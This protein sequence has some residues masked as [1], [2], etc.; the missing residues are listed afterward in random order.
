[1]TAPIAS[2]S[3]I[4]SGIQWRDLVD[5]IMEVEATRRFNPLANRQAAL[6]NQADAWRQFQGVAGTFRDAARRL[7]QLST[8]NV[9]RTTVGR[10]ATGRDVAT[11]SAGERAQPGT[12]ALEVLSTARAEKLGGAVYASS[13]AA[14]GIA[15]S[16][17]V[18]G[19]SITLTADDT[20]TTLRDRINASASGA[21][22]AGVTA[23]L[24]SAGDGV[25]LVL[26]AVSTGAAGID[27]TDDGAGTL[28][29]LGLSDGVTTA[30]IDANGA[31]RTQRLSSST[32]A[33]AS[34]LGVPLPT[35]STIRV[36]GQTI[37]VDLTT[38]SLTEIATKIAAATGDADAVRVESETVGSVTRYWL[39]TDLPVEAD[40]AD[41]VQS[42][43]TLAVLGFTREGRS[44]IAQVVAG[45]EAYGDALGG[46][47]TGSTLLS[48]LTLNGQGLAIAN[49]DTITIGGTRGD[50]TSVSRTFTVGAGSTLQD[51]VAAI[52][53][54]S[55][56]FGSGSRT[57]TA[58]IVDGRVQLTDSV[59]GD[60]ALGL[61]LTLSRASGGQIS[62][63]AF[64]TSAGTVGRDRVL[65]A[66]A[67]A[68]ARIDGQ[69]VR[70]STNTFT[71][72]VP[73][74]TINALAASP[75]ELSTIQVDRDVDAMVKT[76]R[77]FATAY[78]AVQSWVTTNSAQGGPLANN[79]TLRSMAFGLSAALLRNVEGAGSV[80][81]SASLAGLERDRNGVLSLNESKFR[82]ALT[83]DLDGVR[84]LFSSTGSTTDP[85]LAFITGGEATV[86]SGSGYAVEITQVATQAATTGAAW[87]TYSTSGT[88]DTMS[89]TDG[90]TGRSVDVSLANGD[91]L[92]TI[93]ARLNAA[94][95]SQG[96]QLSAER[97]VGGELRLVSSEFGSNGGFTVA[98]TP[99]VGGDGTALLGIA[100]GSYSGLDVAGTIN[101]VAG[102]GR[103]QNL[104]GATG[105]ASAGLVVRYTG[106]TAR[107]AGTVTFGLGVGG[108]LAR[109]ANE[110]AAESSG[111]A[112]QSQTATLQADAI[113]PRLDDIQKRLDAR[114][115]ALVR[116]FVAMEGALAQSQALSTALTSQI[117]SLNQQVNGR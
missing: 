101:G 53:G 111:A 37:S 24:V 71:D 106:A 55:S 10:T 69:F 59:A 45:A 104:T 22:A 54:A 97:T 110:I 52:N 5:Q 39:E 87:A 86:P 58:S 84:R 12:Y 78:N 9:F 47:A 13:T 56:G 35:P 75:G 70:R 108:V 64:T 32:A 43:R 62:L 30:N 92:E 3:G 60:S 23:T 93:V 4:A 102:T 112:Q 7:Q 26:T 89:I 36:G 80:Y 63:G 79:S 61:S 8:F 76:L 65:A 117:N 100:A 21:G 40:G 1:M 74:L 25:R 67:D 51:L 34:I 11:V 94:F 105:D 83:A 20:L 68:T 17:A 33:I 16:F 14:L 109:L 88:P 73:G 31:T 98:Y 42:A 38:D 50:G 116:Q 96:L 18:N 72:A 66:G 115:D 48:N 27:L 41:P 91:T 2:F 113:D 103:G 81:T 29:A 19:R 99:G 114:R 15:G 28:S 95:T 107:V 90:A 6:R 57:A 77:D 85:S 44:G 49:G 82:T 46:A